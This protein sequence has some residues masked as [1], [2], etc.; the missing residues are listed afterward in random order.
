M[1]A[2]AGHARPGDGAA[3]GA[4]AVRSRSRPG[5]ACAARCRS[6]A[7]PAANAPRRRAG[8]AGT[9]GRI[10]RSHRIGRSFRSAEVPAPDHCSPA[11]TARACGLSSKPDRGCR[12]ARS[13]TPPRSGAV[14]N[15]RIAWLYA[16]TASLNWR[17]AK[18]SAVSAA[19]SSAF[20]ADMSTPPTDCTGRRARASARMSSARRRL[21]IAPG[22]PGCAFAWARAMSVCWQAARSVSSALGGVARAPRRARRSAAP[23]SAW[24]VLNCRSTGSKLADDRVA[25]ADEAVVGADGPE[26]PHRD[27]DPD[28]DLPAHRAS[29]R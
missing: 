21:V 22:A 12:P 4:V 9:A 14:G 1:P 6:S 3:V 7:L 17:R 28:A 19:P 16:S 10:D 27:D 15:W 25:Q 8:P 5:C 23:S 20:S 29:D 18:A 13:R 24:R 26:Q 2:S 11:A